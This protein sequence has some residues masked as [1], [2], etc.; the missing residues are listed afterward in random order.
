MTFPFLYKPEK[1]SEGD[2]NN[3][4]DLLVNFEH[5]LSDL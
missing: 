4:F 1:E 5:V 2:G 3:D